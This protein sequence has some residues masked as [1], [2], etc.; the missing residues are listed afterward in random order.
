MLSRYIK[1]SAD[2]SAYQKLAAN[3]KA[4]GNIDRWQATL[5]EFLNKALDLGLDHAMVR[6]EIANHY[7]GLKQWDKAR[8]YAEGAATSGAGWAM[9]CAGRCAE[10]EKD[11]ERAEEWYQRVAERYPDQSWAVWYFF[12][13]R[14]GHG[15]LAAARESVDQYVTAHA[16]HPTI[17]SEESSGFFYWVDGRIESAKADLA[18]AY[19]K[20]S[21]VDHGRPWAWR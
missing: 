16:D 10:G 20:I 5:D 2:Q 12:C 13:K 15:N 19:A 1:L 17:L 7:M 3:F 21:Y 18:K 9:E 6:V 4:Q 14:S 8:P 11:W